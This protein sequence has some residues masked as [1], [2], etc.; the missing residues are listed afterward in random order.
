VLAYRPELVHIDRIDHSSDHVHGQKMD[1]LRRTR[2]YQPVLTDVRSIAPTGWYGSP[3]FATVE[4]AQRMLNTV[5]DSIAAK[6]TEIL[7]Q[8]DRLRGGVAEI[9]TVGKVR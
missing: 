4:K 5:A 2:T 7:R 8:L 3:Q 1:A 6:S 9:N